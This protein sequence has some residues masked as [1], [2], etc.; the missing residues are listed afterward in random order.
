MA[1]DDTTGIVVS[2]ADSASVHIGKH[3]LDLE[4]WEHTKDDSRP[5]GEGGGT[6][7]RAPGFELREFD[8]LHLDLDRVAD[9]FSDPDMVVFASRH[10]G[11]TGPLLTAHHTGNF[12]PAEYGG[13]TGEFARACPNAQAHVLDALM[14]YAPPRYDIGMEC[15]HHGPTDVGAPSMFVELG[16][17]EP[18]WDDPDGVR[19]VAR[20]ILVLRG[21]A[22]ERDRQVVGF[23]G[24]HY[25]PRFERVVSKTDWAVGHIGADWALSAMGDLNRDVLTQAFERSG[26]THA[27]I[28]GDRPELRTVIDDLGY[29]IVSETW[30]RETTGIP[31]EFVEQAETRLTTIDGGLRFGTPARTAAVEDFTTERLP[32]AL[33]EE[34]EGIDPEATRAAVEGHALAFDTEQ[35][36]TRLAG[37]VVLRSTDNREEIDDEFIEILGEKYETVERREEAVVARETA[38]DPEKAHEAGVPEGPKFGTLAGGEPVTIDGQTVQPEAVHTE[39]ERRFPL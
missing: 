34:V 39:R 16:S 6:V 12:G 4:D 14:E 9:A 33:L 1:T 22:P 31:L 3:L 2:R 13:R 8:G 7:H 35:G 30:L 15:T 21:V 5:D 27:L 26:A 29:R 28:E 20:A 37:H 38:F 11:D 19:A 25:V 17:G 36:G 18:E 10:A 24:G 32:A 23:G